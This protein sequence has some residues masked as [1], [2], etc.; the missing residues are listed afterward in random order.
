VKRIVFF[1]VDT[2]YDFMKPRGKLYVKAAEK[3]IPNIKKLTGFADKHKITIV[4]SMDAHINKDPEF[5]L[6]PAHCQRN[7]PGAEKLKETLASRTRQI[8]I[9]KRTF[10]VFSNPLARK[11]VKGF[12]VAYVYGV[13]LDYC[14]KSACLGLVKLGIKTNLVKD[15]TKAV[16]PGS[17]A[18]TLK[19]LKAKG[20]IFVNTKDVFKAILEEEA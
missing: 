12:K 2:Q 6:F 14:V 20:V 11:A 3:L 19:L 18:Q 13:A 8:F 10:D 7:S 17:G 9:S 15:A 1:D 5:A 16:S 4:S